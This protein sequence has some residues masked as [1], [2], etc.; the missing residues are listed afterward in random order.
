MEKKE[1]LALLARA[2]ELTDSAAAEKRSLTDGEQ[3]EVKSILGKVKAYKS[4]QDSARIRAKLEGIGEL[5]GPDGGGDGW[6]K[7]ARA[8]AGGE[9]RVQ[10]G[11][12]DLLH[13]KA[14]T[15]TAVATEAELEVPGIRPMPEDMR[16]VYQA[17]GF[18]DP[19]AA[20][21]VEELYVASRD[22]SGAAVERDPMAVTAKSE[23][24]VTISME[25]S[26]IRQFATLVSNVP[27]AL[28]D[29]EPQLNAFLASAMQRELDQGLDAHCLAKMDAAATLVTGGSGLVPRVRRAITDLHGR[30]ANPDTVVIPEEDLET[31]EVLTEANSYPGWPFGLRVITHPGLGGTS[32]GFVFDSRG[33]I[34]YRGRAA[35]DRDQYTELATNR[36]RLRL[37]YA[38]LLIIRFPAYFVELD[39]SI[40]T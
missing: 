39:T 35:L 22:K 40:V 34:L 8:M 30:G 24:D 15:A 33:A 11:L 26:D 17:F 2:E 3:D 25:T 38:A 19:G 13:G 18:A 20:L 32:N 4:G 12:G 7:A 23:T 29:A 14:V 31:L 36:S 6:A 16:S 28:F 37:E 9:T 21:H 10:L 1:A 27:N 5:A